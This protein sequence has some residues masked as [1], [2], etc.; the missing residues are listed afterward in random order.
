M[1]D[2]HQ[3]VKNPVQPITCHAWN[4][5]R[6]RKDQRLHLVFLLLSPSSLLS[7]LFFFLIFVFDN[8]ICLC[9]FF[10]LFEFSFVCSLVLLEIALS[11]NSEEVNILQAKAGGFEITHTLKEV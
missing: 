6:S 1:T 4:A 2:K 3:L 10:Y 8:F 9:L 11:P 7:P 5:N